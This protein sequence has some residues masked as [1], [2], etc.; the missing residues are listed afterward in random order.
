MIVRAGF[1]GG[2]SDFLIKVGGLWLI[3]WMV[4]KTLWMIE[5]EGLKYGMSKRTEYLE[6]LVG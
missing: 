5:L 1:L 6:K 2:L 3:G 4:Y